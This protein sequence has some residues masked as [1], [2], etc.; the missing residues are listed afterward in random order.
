[1][2]DKTINDL[3]ATTSLSNADLFEL[4][5]TG[6]N[7][8]KIT[9]F[10]AKSYFAGWVLVDTEVIGGS[11]AN[12]DFTGLAGYADFLIVTRNITKSSSGLTVLQVSVDNGSSFYTTSGDYVF[13]PQTG[14]EANNPYFASF[15]ITNATAARSGAVQLPGA[16][17]N[18]GVKVSVP[19]TAGSGSGDGGRFFVASTS[20]IN[21]LRVLSSAGNLTGGTIYLFAR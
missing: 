6:N 1:M 9:A 19:L 17:V 10:N 20:P 8:R 18:G 2:A 21:A 15:H 12:V 3:T 11:V 13:V 7:S 14:A 5:N 16:G 4:E